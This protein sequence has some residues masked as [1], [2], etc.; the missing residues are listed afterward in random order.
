MALATGCAASSSEVTDASESRISVGQAIGNP[1]DEGTFR[2]YDSAEPQRDARCDVYT[3]LELTHLGMESGL[4]AQLHEAVDGGCRIAL[5]ADSR[6]YRLVLDSTSCGSKIYKSTS[7]DRQITI[8]DHRA[9]YCHD[10]LAAQV[11]VE[12]GPASGDKRTMYSLDAYA[13][14]E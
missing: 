9:R 12:E 14:A 1:D 6:E 8:T 7:G 13:A 11:L 2:L 5:A 4:V 3:S 10:R